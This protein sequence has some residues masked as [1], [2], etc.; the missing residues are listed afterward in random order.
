MYNVPDLSQLF[1][2]D[3]AKRLKET[4][5]SFENVLIFDQW[6]KFDIW[7]Y[8]PDKTKQITFTKLEKVNLFWLKDD[9]KKRKELK[10][11][12]TITAEE[13]YEVAGDN[14]GLDIQ[15]H[16]IS[17]SLNDIE[18]VVA[19]VPGSQWPMHFKFTSYGF[20]I[21]A[22]YSRKGVLSEP[23]DPKEVNQKW[24]WG[25][26]GSG[27]ILSVDCK[28]ERENLSEFQVVLEGPNEFPP[29]VVPLLQL[30][31]SVDVDLV[32]IFNKPPNNQ[33]SF[34]SLKSETEIMARSKVRWLKIDFKQEGDKTIAK[35]F[36]IARKFP[37]RDFDGLITIGVNFGVDVGD[38]IIVPIY[39]DQSLIA[40]TQFRVTPWIMT[41]NTLPPRKLYV[42]QAP[43]AYFTS[44]EGYKNNN[45]FIN[46]LKTAVGQGKV[47]VI[48]KKYTRN[49]PW[50]QDEIEFGYS[51]KNDKE[52]CLDVVLNSPR[53]RGLD[54]FPILDLE[55][56]NKMGYISKGGTGEKNSLDSFGN[57]EV[58]PPV[59]DYP[60]GRIYHGGPKEDTQGR[61]M[62][63]AVRD[64]L[65]AQQVQKPLTLYS[66]WLLVGHVD[67]FMSFV[68]SF[69]Q[70]DEQKFRLLLSSP[71]VFMEIMK[72]LKNENKGELKLF[73]GKKGRDGK[74]FETTV[75][76]ILNDVGLQ[77]ANWE[78]QK[79]IDYNRNLLKKELG[80]QEDDII[81]IPACFYPDR[82]KVSALLPGLVNLVAFGKD[83]LLA[84][85]FGP[86]VDGKCR[87][88]QHVKEKLEPL[89]LK[90][91]FIDD[92][93]VY[94]VEDG[95]IHCG[96]NVLRKPF[97]YK[98]WEYEKK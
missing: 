92:W 40:S 1:T 42:S 90:C 54:M 51:Q 91:H 2:K 62:M 45:E 86:V 15:P 19:G 55:E 37:D 12:S 75:D 60:L 49:D 76:K 70:D 50:M 58:T 46:Q 25:E 17:T 6:G 89:D 67:E 95:E 39:R 59:K 21:K 7:R 73:Q 13:Y 81:D 44:E 31:H 18:I 66:D 85:P 28:R 10:V 23:K 94:H 34:D 41:P 63:L 83:L 38:N 96:T 69:K 47:E 43:Y 48:D 3:G 65:E 61:E 68:P 5:D 97:E 22:D 36:A 87:I 93:D 57:L 16:S 32:D 9:D 4:L 82:D 24:T 11:G 52:D 79:Y 29:H 14:E 53:N 72:E 84:K 80:L 27:P 8:L 74:L 77:I 78:C 64:F 98:W 20:S 71:R 30:L 35:F 33:S 56:T 26:K 88:E